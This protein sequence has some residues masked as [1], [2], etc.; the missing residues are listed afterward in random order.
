MTI[1]TRPATV[2]AL[3]LIVAAFA[4]LL[5]VG[6]GKGSMYYLEV[7]EFTMKKSD[8]AGKRIR[9]HGDVVRKTIH[10]SAD[11]QR[12]AFDL[13]GNRGG[14]RVP[15]LYH[16][17]PPDLFAR[18]GVSIVAQ[19]AWDARRKIFAADRLLVKCPSKYQRREGRP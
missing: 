6:L 9:L 14:Q 3:G 16:G 11:R 1:R 18:A 15:V 17:A 2:V 10:Y 7:S 12:L 8:L 19:G 5:V 13:A 4:A